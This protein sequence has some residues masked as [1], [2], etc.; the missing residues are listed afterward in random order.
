MLQLEHQ[1]PGTNLHKYVHAKARHRFR[2]HVYK[3]F[4]GTGMHL[5]QKCQYVLPKK[6]GSCVDFSKARHR[7]RVHVY[8]PFK[9]TGMH[10]SQK[11]QYVLPKKLGSCV[12]FSVDSEKSYGVSNS[13]F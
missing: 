2:V 5:S 8:K 11:F 1:A 13:S 9:G 3:P 10:L 7:F 4:K 6:L 12:D